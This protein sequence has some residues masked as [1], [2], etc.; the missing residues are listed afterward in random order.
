MSR[1]GESESALSGSHS[2]KCVDPVSENVKKRLNV[3][4]PEYSQI[5]GG[6]KNAG[7]N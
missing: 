4:R 1:N 3:R 2:G 5:V 6:S 7:E